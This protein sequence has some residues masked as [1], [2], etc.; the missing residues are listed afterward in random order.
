MMKR[1]KMIICYDGSGYHGFQVQKNVHTVCGAFQD[2]VERVCGSRGSVVGCSRTDT[3]VHALGYVLVLKVETDLDAYRLRGNL[4]GVLP[5][6]IS[7]IASEE[8]DE[9]FHPRYDVSQKEYVYKIFNSISRNPFMEGRALHYVRPIDM[10]LM[11]K[12]CKKFVGTHDFSAFCSLKSDMEDRVRSIT[13]CQIEKDAEIITFTV[14]GDGFLYNMVRI[15]IGTLLWLNEGRIEL[16]D[17]EKIIDGR[18]RMAAGFTAPAHGLYLKRV[19]YA[20][21]HGDGGQEN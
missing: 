14:R 7:V 19:I 17:I 21:E 20:K 10:E 5:W 8:C 18:D 15:M 2:G 11:K 6:D 9:S 13:Y 4:N 12:A 1:F 3:G 16:S